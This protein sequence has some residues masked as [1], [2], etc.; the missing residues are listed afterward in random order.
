MDLGSMFE[1]AV[2]RHPFGV[3]LVE[4]GHSYT[5]L[6]LNQEVNRVASS[7]RKLGIGRRDRVMVLLKNRRQTVCL[8]W[9]IQ[10]LGAIFTPVNYHMSIQDIQHCVYDVEPKVIVFEAVAEAAVR[11]L[12][13]EET[14]IFISLEPD[15]GD[16]SY[17]ELVHSGEDTFDAVPVD[18]DEIAIMLYTSGT[19][20]VPKGVPRSHKNEYASTLA[21]IIQNHYD[22]FDST[23]GIMPLYHTMGV[24]SLLAMTFLNAKF[25]VAQDVRDES[26]PEILCREKI[27][28]L[29]MIPTMYRD[30]LANHRIENYDLSHLQKI[31]YAGAPMPEALVSDC[32]RALHPQRFVNHY[33]STEIHTLTT[34]AY[35][36]RKPGS[37]GK[38][39]INQWIRLMS[40]DPDAT[41]NDG[42]KRGEVGQVIAHLGSAEAFKGYWNRPEVTRQ[43][44][45]DDWYL[46][47]DLGVF[48]DEGDLFVVG[49]V[50][51]MVISGL[52]R[53]S[54]AK[55]EEVLSGHPDVLEV[56]VVGEQDE[57]LGQIVV[58]YVVPRCEQLSPLELDRYCK[59][60]GRLSTFERPRK[61]VF[62]EHL[63]RSATGKVMRRA[64]LSTREK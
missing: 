5:F 46:T 11:K 44:I 29:Y 23:L 19:S 53:V 56:A 63:P 14:P 62:V 48:D 58:A 9:A 59:Q 42:V 31:A 41:V 30:L 40:L 47:G 15:D 26:V 55:V 1:F 10:K 16:I 36:H 34:C 20:G 38:P 4:G 54:P 25:V 2:G 51:E 24:H 61:H 57:H 3:A 60:S 7:L 12:R 37:A 8:F 22:P 35:L 13:L 18:D 49:R 17:D 45:Q 43:V 39:G 21:H 52:E 50:D 64:L 32:F 33:G 27:T 28:C 6:A